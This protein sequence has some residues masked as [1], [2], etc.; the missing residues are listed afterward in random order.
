MKF[1]MAVAITIALVYLLDDGKDHILSLIYVVIGGFISIGVYF[2]EEAETHEKNMAAG[3]KAIKKN[4]P[5]FVCSQLSVL[6]P[7]MTLIGLDTAKKEICIIETISSTRPVFFKPKDI[8]STELIVDS[9]TVLKTTT[10]TSTG[11]MLGR[12]IAGTMLLGGV[13]TIIGGVTAK[14]ESRSVTTSKPQSVEV[15]LGINNFLNP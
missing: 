6:R 5:D 13:G 15:L 4:R 3:Q 7:S 8:V 14:K 12:S 11:S 9:V 10:T 2:W 1:Y